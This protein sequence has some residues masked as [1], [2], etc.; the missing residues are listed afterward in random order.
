MEN[1]KDQRCLFIGI[2]SGRR[3]VGSIQM[4]IEGQK[5]AGNPMVDVRGVHDP[6]VRITYI[7]KVTGRAGIKGVVYWK[8]CRLPT[9]CNP[10]KLKKSV[11]KRRPGRPGVI[12]QTG[13]TSESKS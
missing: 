9:R 6:T 2:G 3:T 5:Y 12:S 7:N 1:T 11:L 13:Q 8:T 10:W 4:G